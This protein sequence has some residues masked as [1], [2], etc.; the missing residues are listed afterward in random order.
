MRSKQV[1]RDA[2]VGSFSSLTRTPVGSRLDGVPCANLLLDAL[3]PVWVC[4]HAACF[5]S[6]GLCLRICLVQWHF[7]RPVLLVSKSTGITFFQFSMQIVLLI[8][9]LVYMARNMHTIPVMVYAHCCVA[10]KQHDLRVVP[11]VV[12]S[13]RWLSI[14]ALVALISFPER[15][16]GA[17][18]LVVLYCSNCYT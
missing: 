17:E 5:C 10:H 9:S 1:K 16:N 6:C 18:G 11:G 3:K 15:A 13:Y 8:V 14:C 2:R 4:I 7:P 12:R